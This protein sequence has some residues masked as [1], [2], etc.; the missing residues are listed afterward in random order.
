VPEADT[1]IVDVAGA[2]ATVTLNRPERLNAI[3]PE[4][5]VRLMEA[6]VDLDADPRVGCVVLTGSGRGFCAGADRSSLEKL[7]SEGLRTRFSTEPIR[8]DFPFRMT[9]PLVAAVNGPVAGTGLS[10]ALMADVR[11]AAE[12]ATWVASFANLGLVA[13]HGVS[14]LLPRLVGMGAALEILL[15]AEPFTSE[16]AYR[17]GLV[18]RLLPA[19]RVLPAAQEFAA[20]VAARSPHSVQ[21]IKEQ[22]RL[23]AA[24]SWEDAFLDMRARAVAS[25]EGPDFREAVAARREGRIPEYRPAAAP[26][27]EGPEGRS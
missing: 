3:T 11:F 14:W 18:Q 16:T 2:V 6:L 17:I 1:I 13:E 25:V 20:M 15:S 23:D 24:R 5:R 22:V 10:Y 19:G 12:G 27:P 26:E 7:T 8:T 21:S 4:M 9:T